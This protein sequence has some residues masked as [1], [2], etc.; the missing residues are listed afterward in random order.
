MIIKEVFRILRQI[1]R[2]EV[3]SLNP[4]VFATFLSYFEQPIMNM[5]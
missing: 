4:R 1:S 2:K 5:W 3:F